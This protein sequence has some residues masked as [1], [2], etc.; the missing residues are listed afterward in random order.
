MDLRFTKMQGCGNDFV[1]IDDRELEWEFD[2]D[3]VQMLCDRH[4]GIGADGIILVRPATVPGAEFLMHY[5]NSDGSL[6]EMCGNGV[7]V[8]AKYLVD[9][10]LVDGDDFTVQT[11]GGLKALTVTRDDDGLVSAARVDMGEPVLEPALIPTTLA[12][13]C[14]D[15]AVMDCPIQT[16]LGEVRVTCVSMGNPHA[17][18][19]VDDVD[20]APVDT[21]GP[22][23]ECHPAFPLR[24]NVEFAQMIDGE[25]RV[26]LRVWER[27]CGETLACGTGACATAVAAVLSCRS[28][29]TC[30]VEL[31]GGDLLIGWSPDGH[32]YMTGPAEEVFEGVWSIP[33][34]E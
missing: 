9:R 6:A 21:L 14:V 30:T 33:D 19:W 3:A 12:G 28:G 18:I 24:T 17:V 16:D 27:G 2:E 34:E 31:P 11:R 26:R 7:R 4:F 22:L 25:D 23:V 5:V 8:F 15:G 20:T 29:R 13:E 1:V 32:V 10:G